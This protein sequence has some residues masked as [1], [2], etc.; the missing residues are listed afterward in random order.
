MNDKKRSQKTLKKRFKHFKTLANKKHGLGTYSYVFT[1]ED[2]VT[3]REKVRITCNK[4]N[5]TFI[6]LPQSHTAK[7]S[8]RKGACPKCHTYGEKARQN[9]NIRWKENRVERR[10]TFLKRMKKRHNGLYLY[11]YIKKEFKDESSMIT[12][13]CTK[14]DNSFISKAECL[15]KENRY[16]GCKVCNEENMKKTIAEKNRARQLRN[17]TIKD[18]LHPFGFIYK[19]TNTI[20]GKFYIGYTNMTIERRFKSHIDESRRLARG[21]RKC[22][23][24][25]HNAMNHH[26]IQSFTVEVLASFKNITP[27]EMGEIEKNYIAVFK[28]DYNL[29]AGGELGNKKLTS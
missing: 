28:P 24:Y 2:Y 11:P 13:L 18:E 19:I 12:V 7:L 23:S 26:G 1:K 5:E 4:C 14:C 9:I 27:I 10:K 29:S 8:T 6:T 25:L 22:M 3:T 17:Y 16:A 20:N 15:K 21:V